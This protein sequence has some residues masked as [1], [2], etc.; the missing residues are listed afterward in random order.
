MLLE[1]T[2]VRLTDKLIP[3]FWGHAALWVGERNQL[4]ALGVW[5]H[6]AVRPY[7]DVIESGGRIVE[8]LRSGVELNTL[9]HF[10][11]I[12]DFAALRQPGLT[13]E[14]R[15]RY[16]VRTFQQIGKEYDFNY[17]VESDRRIVCS[18]LVYVV[19][20]DTTFKVDKAGGRYTIS[21]DRVA[22]QA[23]G[24]GPFEPVV[25]YHDGVEFKGDVSASF[26]RL[27]H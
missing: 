9:E 25:L 3:G 20:S 10:L 1:K 8:A 24:D 13:R 5:E 2:P 22:E 18:E 12:D 7:H 6:E 26:Q 15:R 17:D 27:L 14:Q 16:L 19:Y 11:D 23:L 4:E 21:P